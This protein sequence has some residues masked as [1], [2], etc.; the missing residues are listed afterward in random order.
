MLN[1]IKSLARDERTWIGVG[2]FLSILTY[3]SAGSL[4]SILSAFGAY[5]SYIVAVIV[6]ITPAI[7]Q[8]AGQSFCKFNSKAR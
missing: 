6:L 8:N 1:R 3:V 7:R 5:Q 4:T 2:L